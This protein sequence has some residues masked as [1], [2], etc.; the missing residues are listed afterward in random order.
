[1][2]TL[3]V[4]SNPR[5]MNFST[6]LPFQLPSFFTVE[7]ELS[8]LVVNC[9]SASW[10]WLSLW[11][12]SPTASEVTELRV[13]PT[14]RQAGDSSHPFPTLATL[15]L[16]GSADRENVINPAHSNK[17]RLRQMVSISIIAHN[18]YNYNQS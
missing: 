13:T 3:H 18:I 6:C 16:L 4:N 14:P 10:L 9:P 1:M 5:Q 12:R 17:A 8:R 7:I 15:Q 2:L 11:C